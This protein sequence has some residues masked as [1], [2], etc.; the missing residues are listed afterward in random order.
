MSIRAV[1]KLLRDHPEEAPKWIQEFDNVERG[2]LA[3]IKISGASL[4]DYLPD[5]ADAFSALFQLQLFPPILYG[6]GKTLTERLEELG[7]TTEKHPETGDRPACMWRSDAR[8]RWSA[9]PDSAACRP[10]RGV[11]LRSRGRASAGGRTLG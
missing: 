10:P 5:I 7:I 2:K 1:A 9:A 11:P 6:W 4:D 8:S 3:L